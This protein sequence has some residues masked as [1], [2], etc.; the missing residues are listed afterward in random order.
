MREPFIEKNF[1][2]ESL[3]LI[4]T[5]NQV[6]EAYQADGYT[7]TLRQL[8]Y[9]LVKGIYIENTMKSYKRLGSLLNDARLAG[10]VDWD[11]IEDRT[12]NLEGGRGFWESPRD[13][14]DPNTAWGYQ[15]NPWISQ[16]V[17]IEVWVEKEALEGV[18]ERAC[19]EYRVPFLCCRGYM[20]QS[21]Q[22]AAAKRFQRY[23]QQEGVQ[24]VVI[25]LGDHDPSG[26]D[27]TRDNRDRLDLL[28]WGVPV[29]V[30]RI[31]LN[32]DQVEEL[33]LPP[34]PAKVTDSRAKEYMK[35]FGKSSWELDA[36]EPK[37]INR[38]VND[39]VEEF[40]DLDEWQRALDQESHNQQRIYDAMQS[41]KEAFDGE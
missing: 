10:L 30:R 27:M 37:Y 40:L 9:Q 22:Y 5:C 33:K 23:Y 1:K 4:E 38:I 11:A 34:N 28:S 8:Y 14:M 39:T 13:Y 3:A 35:R 18:I 12:R 21:E 25:H 17:R 24:P 36:L 7:L 2:P 15:E 6:I 31:A 29:E 41:A 16:D 19:Q 32:Q 26:I 20:S